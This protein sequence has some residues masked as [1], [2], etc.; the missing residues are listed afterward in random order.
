M[1]IRANSRRSHRNIIGFMVVLPYLFSNV[2][3]Y[4]G[5]DGDTIP[6]T[7]NAANIPTYGAANTGAD[8]TQQITH[9]FESSVFIRL[10]TA[11][12]K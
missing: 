6:P 9:L 12:D 1:V 5:P 7:E 3:P 10:L 4:T 8:R 11:C 2:T